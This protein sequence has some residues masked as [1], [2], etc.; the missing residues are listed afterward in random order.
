MLTNEEIDKF[1]S[2]AEAQLQQID[3]LYEQSQTKL[4]ALGE[5]IGTVSEEDRK[6]AQQMLEQKKREVEIEQVNQRY[7]LE[8]QQRCQAAPSR[9][10]AR[11]RNMI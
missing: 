4:K 3:R 7:A 9:S 5:S 1:L 11:R 6:V 10:H 2:E 8:Q